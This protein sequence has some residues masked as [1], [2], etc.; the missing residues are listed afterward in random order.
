MSL[1]TGYPSLDYSDYMQSAKILIG[2]PKMQNNLG[3]N[4]LS[5]SFLFSLC[6]AP[7]I[8]IDLSIVQ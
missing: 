1:S 4:K 6:I 8:D 3:A 2:A 5:I 7:N